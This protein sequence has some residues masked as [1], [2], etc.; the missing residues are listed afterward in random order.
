[1]RQKS[2]MQEVGVARFDG[3][4][5]EDIVFLVCLVRVCLYDLGCLASWERACFSRFVPSRQS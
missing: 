3:F 5:S 1:M 4:A 2:A